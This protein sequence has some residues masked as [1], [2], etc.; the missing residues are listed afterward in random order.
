M[1][2][3]WI[4]PILIGII[5]LVITLSY[6]FNN[7]YTAISDSES[8]YAIYKE[9]TET[10]SWK[11]IGDNVLSSCLMTTLLPALI[12]RVVRANPLVVFNLYVSIVI[13][14][15]PIVIFL[16]AKQFLRPHYAC[17]ASVFVMSQPYFLWSPSFARINVALIF[18]GLL[19]LV[20]L[21]KS[22][23]TRYRVSAIVVCTVGIVISHYGTAFAGLFILG[24][25]W[26]FTTLRG[27]HGRETMTIALV[28]LIVAMFVWYSLVTI[29]PA[30][31]GSYVI[32]DT[33]TEIRDAVTKTEIRDAVTKTEV[34]DAVTKVENENSEEQS[35]W[36][37]ESRGPVIQAAFGKRL[38]VMNI[39]QKIEFVFSWLTVIVMSYGL[40]LM[41][42]KKGELA[43]PNFQALSVVCYSMICLTV[44]SPYLSNVYGISRTY[45]TA[46]IPLSTCFIIG[47]I[48]VAE[49]IKVPPFILISGLLVSF[50][51]C[52]TGIMH[53]MFGLVR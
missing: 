39:P 2:N 10:G 28:S 37:I 25:T 7:N 26:V 48:D 45:Y 6:V 14:F 44:L 16:I 33:A 32:R 53:Q 22:L 9:I 24:L 20:L 4:L 3:K 49:R 15:L 8:E 19:V 13:A 38:S 40:F 41:L 1:K 51:L 29:T 21:R 18:F 50:M 43:H 46:L 11:P 5:G 23:E 17:L 47:G 34:R 42:R 27:V 36:S 35:F 30:T 31:Y 12:Q 52:T